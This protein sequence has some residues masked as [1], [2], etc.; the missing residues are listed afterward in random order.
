MKII[1][2]VDQRSKEKLELEK[3]NFE[4]V[5]THCVQVTREIAFCLS[6]DFEVLR[7]ALS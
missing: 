4:N 7:H 6:I 2:K 5:E 3:N 1:C